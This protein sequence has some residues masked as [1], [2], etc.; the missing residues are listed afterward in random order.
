MVWTNAS[1]TPLAVCR[2]GS[3]KVVSG[4]R[5]ENRGNVCGELKNSF[6]LIDSRLIDRPAVHFR[7]GRRQREHAAQRQRVRRHAGP[8]R[9]HVPGVLALVDRGGGDELRAVEDRAAADGQQELDA[10]R[11]APCSTAFMQVS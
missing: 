4:S 1:T 6:S 9:Q 3:V 8:V 7:A 11:P 10:S 5:I 2:G